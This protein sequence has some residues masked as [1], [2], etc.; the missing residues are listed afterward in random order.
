M[1]PQRRY[2]DEDDNAITQRRCQETNVTFGLWPVI[3]LIITT[4]IS[5][6]IYSS[7]KILEHSDRLTKV[8]TQFYFIAEK[9]NVIDQRLI[10]QIEERHKK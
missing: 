4:V 6:A 5:L 7:S 1:N 9:L 2:N 3:L 10:S 8:E